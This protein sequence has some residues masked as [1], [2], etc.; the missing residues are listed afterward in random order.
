MMGP[1]S[2]SPGM[3]IGPGGSDYCSP[4][5]CG[6]THH[7]FAFGEFLYIRPGNAEVAYAVPVDSASA[8]TGVLVPVGQVRV[9][10]PDYAPAFRVGFG[11]AISPRSILMAT[12]M[13][14]DKDTFDTVSLPG[15]GGVIR[16]LVSTPN[17]I[18]AAGDGLDAAALH[19]T[20]IHVLDLDYKGLYHCS[21]EWQVAYVAGARY[22]NLEQHF[23]AGFAPATGFEEVLAE[24]EFDGGGLK[25]G[26]DIMRVHPMSQFFF[27][28][29]GA[30]S[31]VAGTFR[32]RYQNNTPAGILDPNASFDVGRLV[33]I[34]DMEAGLGWQSFTGNL[35]LSMGYLASVWY[36]T[37]RV[38]EFINSV[39]TVNFA[40][41]SDN[42]N[43]RFTYD[44][45]TAKIELLW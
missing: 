14:F 3:P 18:T 20:Q 5:C 37:V 41:P 15:T 34:F 29:K 10:D 42:F 17:P 21:E 32:A 26:L 16:S 19:Q 25:M 45:L 13:Q 43:G 39:Q 1:M 22:V 31:L 7:W 11:A 8:G 2:G 23:A 40:D 9:A 44:G 30:A 24:S 27:Y 4:D 36:N 35:R 6:W 38:N 33:P 12:Y 28:G